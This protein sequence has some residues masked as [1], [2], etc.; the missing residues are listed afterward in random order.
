M[1]GRCV[2]KTAPSC[3]YAKL[4]SATLGPR[5]LLWDDTMRVAFGCDAQIL[6]IPPFGGLDAASPLI[7]GDEQIFFAR[8][9]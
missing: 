7:V 3:S 2:G 4:R 9:D 6:L 1:R 5:S 8:E